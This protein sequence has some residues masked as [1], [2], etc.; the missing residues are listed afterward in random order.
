MV[1]I[2]EEEAK[3]TCWRIIITP[4]LRRMG[5]LTVNVHVSGEVVKKNCESESITA[6]I[7]SSPFGMSHVWLLWDARENIK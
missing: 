1:T 7:Y 6:A 4:Q 5:V 2:A 3:N